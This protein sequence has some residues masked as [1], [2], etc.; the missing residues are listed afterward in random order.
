MKCP[1][2]VL[3]IFVLVS[4]RLLEIIC[5][6]FTLQFQNIFWTSVFYLMRHI[7]FIPIFKRFQRHI[8][9]CSICDLPF[10]QSLYFENGKYINDLVTCL[11][12][13]ISP[14]H[15]QGQ[16]MLTWRGTIC[17]YYCN[18]TIISVVDITAI[19]SVYMVRCS[20]IISV[21][22]MWVAEIIWCLD[23]GPDSIPLCFT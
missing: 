8:V 1:K 15:G 10:P 20:K 4:K 18:I 21:L 7:V 2:W 11:F 13:P 19:K 22:K 12:R 5:L 6:S 16:N 9:T 3:L 23:K 14:K 17:R